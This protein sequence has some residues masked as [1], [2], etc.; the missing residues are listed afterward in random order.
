LESEITKAPGTHALDE[1][2]PG[3]A[4]QEARQRWEENPWWG[5]L[6]ILSSAREFWNT[7]ITDM[8][9]LERISPTALAI[10]VTFLKGN[11]E[12]M[13]RLSLSFGGEF[14]MVVTRRIEGDK[15]KPAHRLIVTWK[16]DHTR[17]MKS[18]SGQLIF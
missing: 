17:L 15:P 4:R 14:N 1:V 6:Q 7:V 9:P 18:P 13:P 10:Q 12:A 2:R 11:P 8:T 16:P 5:P 3:E